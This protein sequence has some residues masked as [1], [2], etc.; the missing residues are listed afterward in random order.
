MN[1]N[2]TECESASSGSDQDGDDDRRPVKCGR[3]HLLTQFLIK[4]LSDFCAAERSKN[5][6]ST[7]LFTY[8]N[9][10]DSLKH[11][12]LKIMR[13]EELN[14]VRYFGTTVIRKLERRLAEYKRLHGELSW[15]ALEHCPSSRKVES[16]Q[17]KINVPVSEEGGSSQNV[18]TTSKN[19]SYTPKTGSGAYAVLLTLYDVCQEGNCVH[20]NTASDFELKLSDLQLKA[21]KYSNEPMTKSSATQHYT[22]F[23]CL[24][25]LK[26]KALVSSRK[27]GR[28]DVI[29]LTHEGWELAK[30]LKESIG[31]GEHQSSNKF[32]GK[33]TGKIDEENLVEKVATPVKRKLTEKAVDV[34]KKRNKKVETSAEISKPKHPVPAISAKI[35]TA[36]DGYIYLTEELVETKYRFEACNELDSD[37][38]IKMVWI[39]STEKFMN[40]KTDILFK[41]R[42]GSDGVFPAPFI[43]ACLH[44]QDAEMVA[45]GF[46]E[47]ENLTTIEDDEVPS[48]S[49]SKVHLN[50]CDEELKIISDC[51]D[52]VLEPDSVVLTN[53][54][55]QQ[56]SKMECFG[57]TTTLQK[58]IMK[59]GQ[60]E[61]V[62]LVDHAEIKGGVGT[63]VGD[64]GKRSMLLDYF[65][66]S[67]IRFEC[68]KLN[69][70]DYLWVAKGKN[71]SPIDNCNNELDE[72][73]L[74]L[75]VERK[76]TDDLAKSIKDG[77][78]QSQKFRL[79]QCGLRKV[80]YLFE[81]LPKSVKICALNPQA[82][83]S[84]II[85]AE[86]QDAFTVCK[87]A[88]VKETANFLV[89]MTRTLDELFKGKTLNSVDLQ[90]FD[91]TLFNKGLDLSSE[92][93]QLVSM[94]NY[95]K[96]VE[97]PR[98]MKVCEALTL[99]LMQIPGVSMEL[100]KS[101][102]DRFRT[103]K[104]LHLELNRLDLDQK[105]K[106]ALF[107]NIRSGAHQR[108]LG[109][110]LAQKIV[111]L[112]TA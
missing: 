102:S 74:G 22:P 47:S 93:L 31:S 14:D 32:I 13:L 97:K 105:G 3:N 11:Y 41:V 1:S 9:A 77:R 34:E 64:R 96:I 71:R 112:F 88:H 10:L 104:A 101:I 78:W 21:D 35:E 2:A 56:P 84:A 26:A 75:V 79:K 44:E 40:S 18:P 23:S 50:Q 53:L 89:K 98:N 28:Y 80:I 52:I 29:S 16:K 61:V 86:I 15:S 55:P 5:D 24:K 68:R 38:G 58:I 109:P 70:G 95:Q 17:K 110:T 33:E 85:N 82:L 43:F 48:C 30:K 39:K 63:S 72:L 106:V 37:L 108:R 67:K 103:L 111:D 20:A 6:G 66:Q 4:F 62:L 27:Q 69:A 54:K 45:P 107:E 57:W 87:T 7:L 12:P 8:K 91:Q 36:P 42:P 49:K 81:H 94:E 25:M 59:P 92:T 51:S 100:A 76:R 60:F 90:D 19:K 99:C 73:V 83:E 46:L 65:T